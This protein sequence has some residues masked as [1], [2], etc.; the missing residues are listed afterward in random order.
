LNEETFV[1][2]HDGG[3]GGS[4]NNPMKMNVVLNIGD[5]NEENYLLE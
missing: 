4:D 2:L 1:L 3:G 5:N